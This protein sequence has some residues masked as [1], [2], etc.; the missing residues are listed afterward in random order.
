MPTLNQQMVRDLR[1]ILGED[2]MERLRAA[3]GDHK[4]VT[5]Y[6]LGQKG[7]LQVDAWDH[8]WTVMDH[9]LDTGPNSYVPPSTDR[10]SGILEIEW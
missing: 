2:G 6:L 1:A 10:P 7:W 9:V 3:R 8:F 4:L 5:E